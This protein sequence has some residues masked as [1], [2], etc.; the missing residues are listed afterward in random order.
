MGVVKEYSRKP[1]SKLELPFSG[2][3]TNIS[4]L[5]TITEISCTYPRSLCGIYP[6]KCKQMKSKMEVAFTHTDTD[7]RTI[8]S[9]TKQIPVHVGCSCVNRSSFDFHV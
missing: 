2:F 6:Y 1:N 9:Y 3:V 4:T 8:V 7:N 5:G